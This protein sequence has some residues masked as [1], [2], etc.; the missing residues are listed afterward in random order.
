MLCVGVTKHCVLRAFRE[1]REK[2]VCTNF[3]DQN[4]TYALFSTKVVPQPLRNPY[5]KVMRPN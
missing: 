2:G 5:D 3:I 1:Q 4:F